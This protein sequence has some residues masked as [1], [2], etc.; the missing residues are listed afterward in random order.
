ML[1]FASKQPE[2]QLMFENDPK[3]HIFFHNSLPPQPLPNDK[4]LSHTLSNTFI[5]H[6]WLITTLTLALTL[7]EN[8]TKVHQKT[9]NFNH[10]PKGLKHPNLKPHTKWPQNLFPH[11]MY[12]DLR[13]LKPQVSTNST[14]NPIC[15]QL[16]HKLQDFAAF[17]PLTQKLV[18]WTKLLKNL[19]LN[20][21]PWTFPSW[22]HLQNPNLSHSHFVN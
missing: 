13:L 20:Y 4:F 7:T 1:T 15:H 22:S 11:L 3:I 14:T 9:Y 19:T 8:P 12:D 21:P 6:I 10:V 17:T 18:K 2:D 16:Y 5:W